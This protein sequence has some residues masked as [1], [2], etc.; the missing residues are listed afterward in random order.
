MT[1]EATDEC[2]ARRVATNG[3]KHQPKHVEVVEL[4]EADLRET[5]LKTEQPKPE[6]PVFSQGKGKKSGKKADEKPE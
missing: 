3:S 6:S 4:T 1:V 2:D 5:V